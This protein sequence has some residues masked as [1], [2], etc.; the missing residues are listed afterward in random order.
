MR[1]VLIVSI[2]AVVL[3]GGAAAWWLTRDA[4]PPPLSVD[5]V[6]QQ[7]SLGPTTTGL[8]GAWTVGKDSDSQA[9]LRIVED[10]F[11]GTP[12][13]HRRRP[14]MAVT[15]DLSVAGSTVSSGSFRV[16]LSKIRFTDDPG[17]SVA[18][19]S[20]YLQTRVARDRSVPERPSN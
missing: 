7:E 20:K 16:D 3:A 4:A 11:R 15:G 14:D 6:S 17:L 12:G 13:Q 5:D 9:G 1:R 19:R 8:D 2:V 18:N 10:R